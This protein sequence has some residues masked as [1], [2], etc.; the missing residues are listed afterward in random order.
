M[1]ALRTKAIIFQEVGKAIIGE[2]DLPEP[3][4]DDLVVETEASG[5]SVGTERWAY[6]GKRAEMTFPFVPGYMGIG[7]VIE[8]GTRAAERGYAEG[9]RV[10][11][12]R[13]RILPPYDGSWMSTH[14]ARAVVNVNYEYLPDA[15][16]VHGCVPVPEGLSPRE[17]SL[18]GLCSVAL[19]GIEMAGIPVG[20]KVLVC[21]LGLIGQYAAQAVR[22]KGAQVCVAEINETRLA[23]ARNLGADWA[24]NPAQQDLAEVQRQV[25]PPGFDII[26]DT[27]SIPEVVNGLFPLLRHRGK[28]VFQGWYPPPSAIDINAIHGV[29]ATC[30][31]PCSH[32]DACVAAAMCW[33]AEGRLDVASLITHLVSPAEAPQIYRMIE[34]NAEDFLGIVF[35]WRG[36]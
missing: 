32:N 2:V 26:I 6:I 14:L 27:S 35:D 8:V 36:E 20:A 25:A 4:A 15:L 34:E 31:F 5:V 9:Q 11:F 23:I 1:S 28:F 22:I 16:D 30:Y 19:R 29:M 3:T 17:A 18:T 10:N 7:K 21:G 24:V 12:C 33:A 13:S